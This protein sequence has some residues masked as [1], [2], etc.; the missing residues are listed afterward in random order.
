MKRLFALMLVPVFVLIL[1]A[2][3]GQP[4]SP[5]TEEKNIQE[6]A[7][8]AEQETAEEFD[9]IVKARYARDPEPLRQY[10]REQDPD[11]EL[12]VLMKRHDIETDL[13]QLAKPGEFPFPVEDLE[14]FDGDIL[15]IKTIG[16]I[17]ELLIPGEYTHCGVFDAELFQG[18]L[19]DKCLHSATL[20]FNTEGNFV[21]GVTYESFAD[22]SGAGK[23]AVMRQASIGESKELDHAQRIIASR[24]N[25][26][27][28]AILYLNL[29]PVYRYDPFLWYCS[30]T[31]WRVY[32]LLN[33]DIEYAEYYG[34]YSADGFEPSDEFIELTDRDGER[35]S[36]LFILYYRNVKRHL[37]WHPRKEQKAQEI[38]EA[39]AARVLTELISPD[40]IRHATGDN[41][42]LTLH[43]SLP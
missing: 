9:L 34:R 37:W 28:Y 33:I 29:E 22:W 15:I 30:K 31:S 11:G 16:S 7:A 5:P 42:P 17:M 40:E 12:R 10:L 41:G 13:Q 14:L 20:G 32:D 1:L 6:A 2:C 27:A 19:S 39:W 26:S 35:D 21:N 38:A 43:A 4:V 3:T 24:I 8:L 23:L 25:R 18:N 36:F